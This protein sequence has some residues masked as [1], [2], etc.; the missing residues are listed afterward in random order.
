MTNYILL[1]GSGLYQDNAIKYFHKAALYYIFQ[2]LRK[3]NWSL[4][5]SLE[6]AET[7][8]NSASLLEAEV[9]KK[10]SI[11]H[12]LKGLNQSLKEQNNVG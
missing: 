9:D 6:K 5:E 3:K 12:D 11:V 10:S 7:A 8:A 2:E 1:Q 4:S